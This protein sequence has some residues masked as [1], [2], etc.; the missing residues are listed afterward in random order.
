MEKTV[1]QIENV[2]AAELLERLEAI[3]TAL[4]KIEA[5]QK[6]TAEN[7]AE[8]MSR[9]EVAAFFSITLPTVHD[10]INKGV[11]R[12]YK[13]GSKTYFKRTEVETALA[14]K[15]PKYGTF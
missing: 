2:P 7:A 6:E 3:E 15:R 8:Y 10:W 13:A 11:L 4:Q 1:L 12:A 9:K 5:T 14:A